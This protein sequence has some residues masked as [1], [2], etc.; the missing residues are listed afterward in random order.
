M[1]LHSDFQPSQ[2]IGQRPDL[3]WLP[4][5]ILV[6]DP[7]YQRP[8]NTLRSGRLIR[9]I[10]E[11][12]AWHRLKAPTVSDRGDG[13]FAIID[14]QHTIEAAK[15]HGGIPE[16]P[17]LVVVVP[18][19]RSEADGFVACN[20]QRIKVNE[21]QLYHAKLAAG[22]PDALQIDAICRAAAVSIPRFPIPADKMAPRQTLAIKAIDIAM[23]KHGDGPVIRALSALADAHGDSGGE[24]RAQVIR[25]LIDLIV[26]CGEQHAI[27][28][29]R[30]VKVLSETTSE[31]LIEA[32]R[33]DRR[34]NRRPTETNVQA[35][36]VARYNQRLPEDR[37]LPA[38]F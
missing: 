12:F 17:C 20:E 4:V 21:F 27:D 7:M 25:A 16:L 6:S 26:A 8:T 32:A 24:L 22:D 2:T 29:D 11:G 35:A 1:S 38:P 15:L 14:G 30:L 36:I 5:G 23:R 3:R 19:S 37:R 31:E 10:A 9:A 18:G 28:R 33:T 13:S 34:H